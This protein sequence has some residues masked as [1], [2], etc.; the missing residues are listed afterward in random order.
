MQKSELQDLTIHQIRQHI[1]EGAYTSDT[2]GVADGYVQANL[3]ILPKDVAFDFLVF[4]Q[5]NPKPCPLL[6]VTLPGSPTPE[7]LAPGADLR[8]DV[9]RYRVFRQGELVDEPTDIR[10]YWRDDLVAFLLGCSATFDNALRNARMPLSFLEQ[11]MV[12]PVFETNV[13]CL[14]VGPFH[15]P[16]VATMRPIPDHLVVKAVQL[17]GRFPSAHGTPIQVGYPEKVGVTDLSKP[18][19]GTPLVMQPT[20]VPVFWACGVTPQEVAM[21]SKTDWMITHAPGHMF[22]SDRHYEQDAVV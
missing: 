4:C 13:Q 15:G 22:L 5:R 6:D 12:P 7:L 21:A 16:I 19:Y 1:R 20:D 2:M 10:S 18:K 17:S 3:V 14:P 9:P 8:T 11:G